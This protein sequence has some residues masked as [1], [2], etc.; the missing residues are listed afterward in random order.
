MH[1]FLIS[2]PWFATQQTSL[3]FAEC[4]MMD[5]KDFYIFRFS[6]KATIQY[7]KNDSEK[8]SFDCDN[9]FAFLKNK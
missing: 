9:F 2:T 5:A 4:I 7:L 8:I 3:S 1:I 6:W